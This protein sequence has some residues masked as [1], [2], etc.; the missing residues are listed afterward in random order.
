MALASAGLTSAVSL[1]EPT[2]AYLHQRLGVARNKA[3]WGTSLAIY[4]IGVVALLSNIEGFQFL[5]IGEQSVFDYID[6]FTAAIMLPVAGLITAIFIGY[7]SDKNH[8]F[9]FLKEQNWTQTHFNIWIFSLKIFVPI[10][11]VLV[12]LTSLDFI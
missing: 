10:G 6:F 11:A 2:I 3:V 12:M 7:V 5:A 8:I 4:L 9:M 1:L